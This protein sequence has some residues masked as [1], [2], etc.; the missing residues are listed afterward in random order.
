M[1]GMPRLGALKRS[2]DPEHKPT[3]L[4]KDEKFEKLLK[5]AREEALRWSAATAV[6]TAVPAVLLFAAVKI[7]AIDVR[8]EDLLLVGVIPALSV[9]AFLSM[10]TLL[11]ISLPSLLE[12]YSYKIYSRLSEGGAA[13]PQAAPPQAAIQVPVQ[14]PPTPLIAPAPARASPPSQATAV[15]PAPAPPAREGAVYPTPSTPPEAAPRP[16]AFSPVVLSSPRCPECGR[17]LPYGD[18]H[19]ICPFCGARLK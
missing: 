2:K 1:P 3:R 7:F 17:E 8:P 14:R 15:R 10:Y 19:L 13:S 9:F 12:A 16:A 5:K 11:N 4:P 18:L 6:L